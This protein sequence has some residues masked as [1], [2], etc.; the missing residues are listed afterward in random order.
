MIPVPVRDLING[1]TCPV[2]LYVRLGND[3]F[4]LIEKAGAK[5][6][7]DRL[8]S[9][10]NKTVEYLWVKREEYS[11]LIDN[12]IT[13]AGV[14]VSQQ[15]LSTA[16]KVQILSQAAAGVF[17]ELE[18]IG[19][20][21]DT[22]SHAR[23]VVEV[24]VALAETNNNL[25]HLLNSLNDCSDELLRHSLAVSSVS[26]LIANALNWEN[27]QTVEKLALGALLH[28]IGLKALPPE[29]VN[30]PRALMSFEETQLFEQ[31]PYKGMEMLLTLGMVPDDVVAIVY[32]HHENALGQ[33]YPRKLRNIKMHPLAKVVALANDF[34]EMTVRSAANPQSRTPREALITIET[35][36]GQPHNKEA[37]RALQ[38]VVNREYAK[39]AS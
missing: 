16:Q 31:H 8:L 26:V 19:L 1:S 28:D 25:N 32:E 30:K 12:N 14:M 13:I 7:K 4:V 34:C 18:H 9:Y 15:S 17:T 5:T 11:R 20:S 21:F 29:L 10:E 37:F 38:I 2:N 22:Y 23:Q 24:T 3:K 6:N 33:G 27:K 36:M 35:V 39:V